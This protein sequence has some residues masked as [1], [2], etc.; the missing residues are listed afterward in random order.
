[1]RYYK[2]ETLGTIANTR[3][4]ARDRK[5]NPMKMY[6]I[7]VRDDNEWTPIGEVFFYH[8]EAESFMV[9]Y[10]NKFPFRITAKIRLVK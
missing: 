5:E 9:S 1:M 4:V 8:H 7:Y 6:R 3:A 2:S 10:R